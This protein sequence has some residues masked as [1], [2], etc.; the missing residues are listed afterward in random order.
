ML[1]LL[2]ALANV[3]MFKVL[4]ILQ[5]WPG[6]SCCCGLETYSLLYST[7]IIIYNNILHPLYH[8]II[9]DF[10]SI[11]K[12]ISV[13]FSGSLTVCCNLTHAIVVIWI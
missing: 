3:A 8:H 5:C 11:Y 6:F 13:H 1:V 10:L 12:G 7:I 9:H 4:Y 2:I